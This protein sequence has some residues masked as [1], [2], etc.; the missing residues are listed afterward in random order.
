[1]MKNLSLARLF[2]LWIPRTMV[3][4]V[5]GLVLLGAGRLMQ[6]PPPPPQRALTV[7]VP[8]TPQT[9]SAA[10]EKQLQMLKDE[11]DALKAKEDDLKWI[12]GL[13]ITIAGLFTIAQ[14]VAAWFNA[15]NFTQQAEKLLAD[16]KTRSDKALADANAEAERTLADARAK[17]SVFALLQEQ[18]DAALEKLNSL[19]QILALSSPVNSP[20]EGFDWRRLV[21]EKLP[22]KLRRELLT[23]E[24]VFSYEA[25]GQNDP[26]DV[27]ARN[28]RRLALFYWSK[29]IH[30][31]DWDAGQLVDLEHAEY[32]LGLA[33]SRIGEVF[34]LLND[35]GNIQIELYKLYS[36]SR[37]PVQTAL[38]RA[39]LQRILA[40]ARQSFSDSVGVQR[41]QIRA[42]HNLAYIEAELDPEG[43]EEKRL[44]KA[45]D[46]LREGLKYPNWERAPV[47]EHQCSAQYNLACYYARL[48]Q[49]YDPPK[50]WQRS[51]VAACVAVLRKAAK[52]GLVPPLDVERDFNTKDGDFY[53]LLGSATPDTVALMRRLE[54]ELPRRYKID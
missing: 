31:R 34:Y 8:S 40:R 1:M 54:R 52:G 51:V 10:L 42:Y 7:P 3:L 25:T 30:E 48:S 22:L 28:L 17:F 6:N 53:A 49:L 38:D 26:A 23:A 21:Y 20:D 32:L 11:S 5:A 46:L 35:M 45:I 43:D 29:F 18:R 33:M 16:A 27:C 47:K 44:R 50:G 13:I 41:R 14:G 12:L 39:A 4:V 36:G 9:E 37:P 2:A 19:E 24:Q 15:Q